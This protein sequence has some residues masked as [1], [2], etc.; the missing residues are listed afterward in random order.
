MQQIGRRISNYDS[1]VRR[2]Q[3]IHHGRFGSGGIAVFGTERQPV[4]AADTI[5]RGQC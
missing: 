1:D 3:S 5:F 2:D 4:V